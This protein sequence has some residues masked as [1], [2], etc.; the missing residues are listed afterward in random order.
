MIKAKKLQRM[1]DEGIPEKYCV[2]L[3]KKK[4]SS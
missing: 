2:G 1:V 4:V 3:Q